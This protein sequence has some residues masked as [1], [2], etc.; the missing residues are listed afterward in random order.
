MVVYSVPVSIPT[1]KRG[2]SG[3]RVSGG[4]VAM[5]GSW[6]RGASLIRKRTPLGPYHRPV[7]KVLG[8]SQGGGRFLTGEV[9]LYGGGN[10]TTLSGAHEATFGF[11]PGRVAS[12]A[13]WGYNPV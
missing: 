8:G 2:A 6:H 7:P 10:L 5:H 9:P 1:A 11:V 12:G 4:V 13:L 3:S